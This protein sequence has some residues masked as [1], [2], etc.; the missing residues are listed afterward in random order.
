[1]Y[2]SCQ[3]LLHSIR[4]AETLCSVLSHCNNSWGILW[5]M[6]SLTIHTYEQPLTPRAD[7]CV[8]INADEW[9]GWKGRMAM[10]E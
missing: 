10:G 5:C 3:H 4:S 1:M 9:I 6:C 8:W 7:P 2:L